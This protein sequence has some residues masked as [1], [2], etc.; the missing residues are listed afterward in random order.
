MTNPE[1]Q[2]GTDMGALVDLEVP[3]DEIRHTAIERGFQVVED[4]RPG[5]QSMI[6]VI[7]RGRILPVWVERT[8]DG[9][10]VARTYSNRLELF[11]ER[12]IGRD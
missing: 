2:A 4:L 12:L 3:F 7:E 11:T 8:T 6:I 9:E 5:V 10:S 1:A